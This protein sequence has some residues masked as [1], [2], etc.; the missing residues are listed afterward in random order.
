M[1]LIPFDRDHLVHWI[2]ITH[3]GEALIGFRGG[4]VGTVARAEDGW[5]EGKGGSS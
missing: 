4:E 5:C 3:S 1:N 2:A